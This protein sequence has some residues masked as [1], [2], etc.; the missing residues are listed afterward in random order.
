MGGDGGGGGSAVADILSGT[1]AGIAQV[2][3]GESQD[4]TKSGSKTRVVYLRSHVVHAPRVEVPQKIH[5]PSTLGRNSDGGAQG[6]RG[7]GEQRCFCGPVGNCHWTFD[8]EPGRA[9]VALPFY[10]YFCFSSNPSKVQR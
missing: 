7:M 10:L 1:V 5:L 6:G 2:I 9:Y 8:N 4:K 3:V